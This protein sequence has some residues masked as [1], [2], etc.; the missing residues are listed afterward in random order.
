MIVDVFPV[1]CPGVAIV[2]L[3]ALMVNC[4][5]GADSNVTVAVPEDPA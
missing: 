3:V 4:G 5:I 2:T 1:V